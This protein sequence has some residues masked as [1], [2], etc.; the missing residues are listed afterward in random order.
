MSKLT[1]K[2]E[3]LS[4]AQEKSLELGDPLNLLNVVRPHAAAAVQVAEKSSAVGAFRDGP[5][6]LDS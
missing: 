3:A 6:R 2:F 1:D 5:H 4:A